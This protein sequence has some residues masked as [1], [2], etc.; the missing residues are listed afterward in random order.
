MNRTYE[1]LRYDQHMYET[2]RNECNVPAAI[3]DSIRL[4]NHDRASTGSLLSEISGISDP[5]TDD[6]YL[7]RKPQI[8]DESLID[9][10]PT[11]EAS[12]DSTELMYSASQLMNHSM[13]EETF[14]VNNEHNEMES[15]GAFTFDP[16]RDEQI[17]YTSTEIETVA[18]IEPDKNPIYERIDEILTNA[19]SD[20]PQQLI[21]QK[22]IL[23]NNDVNIQ[24]FK[25]PRN[26]HHSF[27]HRPASRSVTCF[28]CFK[29]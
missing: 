12:D 7:N 20:Q 9:S 3:E 8:D 29:K 14:R 5:Q 10:D 15:S 27:S 24:N 1:L 4:D 21:E 28:L 25:S 6:D 26:C 23:N 18:T 19:T 16:V 17:I 2:M 11:D 13:L 22:P